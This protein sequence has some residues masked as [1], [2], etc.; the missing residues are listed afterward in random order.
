MGVGS[1]GNEPR[2]GQGKKAKGHTE[3]AGKCK[4]R[5]KEVGGVENKQGE[6]SRHGKVLG[7]SGSSH[8][9]R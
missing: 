2:E 9:D 8:E 7:S 6:G 4:T 3:R 1:M 5:V